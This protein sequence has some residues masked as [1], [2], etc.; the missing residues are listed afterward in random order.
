MSNKKHEE[1]EKRNEK[2]RKASLRAVEI[3]YSLEDVLA[4]F[5]NDEK[6]TIRYKQFIDTVSNQFDHTLGDINKKKFEEH[7]SDIKRIKKQNGWLSYKSAII[8]V[9]GAIAVQ[10][11]TT[12]PQLITVIASL[13]KGTP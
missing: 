7:D 3:K 4:S 11:I 6:Q 10:L 1:F 2:W 5:D 9:V 8:A 13:F 12:L